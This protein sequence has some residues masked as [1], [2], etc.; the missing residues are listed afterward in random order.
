[1]LVL[2]TPAAAQPISPYDGHGP[3][4][5]QLQDVGTGTAYPNPGADPFCVE[6]D[7]TQQNVTDFGIFD[8]L[9]KEP[10]RVAAAV[11]KCFY[12]QRDH[13]TGSV[14]Q[15]AP[16][17]LWHW[18]GSYFFDKSNASG[19]VHVAN[20]R[21]GGQPMDAT[22]YAPAEFQ[23]YLAQDGGGGAYVSGQVPADPACAA[24]VDTPAERAQVYYH[25]QPGGPISRQGIGR[26]VLG[27]PSTALHQSEGPAH[28]IVNGTE[29]FNVTGGGQLRLAYVNSLVAAILTTSPNHFLGEVHPG[30]SGTTARRAL[31]ASFAFT[32]GDLAVFEA[33]RLNRSRLL[34]GIRAGSLE[35][36]AIVDPTRI[37]SQPE[38]K[39]TLAA[40]SQDGKGRVD[41]TGMPW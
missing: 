7:K 41:S 19:G 30:V 36:I 2:A 14:V 23:P 25:T 32:I 35:W 1:M 20:F 33:P 27:E 39:R 17:E 37:R 29:R 5:C 9:T 31:H 3:F 38:L 22:P 8:F 18:D 34:L 26:F 6:Y 13:W 15:G 40:L 11:P 12:F 4:N 21:I 10:A 24:K 16:P 28:E